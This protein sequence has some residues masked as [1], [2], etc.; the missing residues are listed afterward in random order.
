MFFPAKSH[1]KC[2]FLNKESVLFATECS[3]SK[4]IRSAFL[5]CSD[6]FWKSY[7]PYFSKLY[8]LLIASR[9]LIKPLSLKTL[10][11]VLELKPS[12]SGFKLKLL[13][14]VVFL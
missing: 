4:E 2:F 11:E 14:K 7:R 12:L 13:S 3:P 1:E 10:F 8:R 9:Q 5:G 6:G